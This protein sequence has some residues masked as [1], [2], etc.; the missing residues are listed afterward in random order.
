MTWRILF[1]WSC[2]RTCR[3]V[4]LGVRVQAVKGMRRVPKALFS[5][6]LHGLHSWRQEESNERDSKSRTL[7]QTGA[8]HGESPRLGR[9]LSWSAAAAESWTL[10]AT[11]RREAPSHRLIEH[12]LEFP[13][14]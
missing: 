1:S 11:R 12:L 13:V 8:G 3:G 14:W 4:F 5:T 9:E 2:D 6:S 7:D 10:Q